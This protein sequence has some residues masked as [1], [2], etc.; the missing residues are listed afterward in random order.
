MSLKRGFKADA[1]RLAAEVRSELDL[2]P[3][4]RLNPHA[5]AQYLGIAVLD[6]AEYGRRTGTEIASRVLLTTERESFSAVTIF[7]GLKR[8]IVRNERNA[9]TR[10][11]SDLAHELAHALLLHSAAPLIDGDGGRYFSKREE[12]EADWLGG[13]LLVPR[14][15]VLT[16]IEQGL[17]VDAVAEHFGVSPRLCRWRLSATGVVRQ[18]TRRR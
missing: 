14:G 16:L 18:L 15:G 4:D 5:L 2:R 11:A 9:R 6:L 8:V 3:V 12:E 1:E 13:T 10:Q 17:A 7:Q